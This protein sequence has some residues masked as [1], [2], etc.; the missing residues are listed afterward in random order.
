LQTS[1]DNERRIFKNHTS[2]R[3]LKTSEL[4][5]FSRNLNSQQ[6]QWCKWIHQIQWQSEQSTTTMDA[7][8]L[9]QFSPNLNS[10]QQE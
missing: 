9:I 3:I 6:Q 1:Y 8:K 5:K 2:T 10:Q 7:N 4:I